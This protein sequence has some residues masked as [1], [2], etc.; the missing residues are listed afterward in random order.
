MG[1]NGMRALVG[2]LLL[3]VAAAFQAQRALPVPVRRGAS[4]PAPSLR[5]APPRGS[6]RAARLLRMQ[7]DVADETAPSDSGSTVAS[8][9]PAADLYR[10]PQCSAAITLDDAACGACGAPF[11]RSAAF[12]DLTP[13]STAK[14][15]RDDNL[16]EQA[17]RNPFLSVAL[18]QIGAQ[19]SGQ[20]C[21]RAPGALRARRARCARGGNQCHPC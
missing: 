2:A 9:T 12:V 10:C 1:V 4:L 14:K 20:V 17:T 16:V 7:V 8:A 13:E 3:A 19:L 5:P 15:A 18:S 11:D 6:G 21:A